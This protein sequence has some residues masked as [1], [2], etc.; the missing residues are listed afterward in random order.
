MDTLMADAAQSNPA[1]DLGALPEWNLADLYPGTDSK[2]LGDDLGG[3]PRD[4]KAFKEFYAGKVASQTGPGLS[5]AIAEYERLD[6]IIGRVISYAQLVYAGDMS[7]S[8]NGKFYQSMQERVTEIGSDL[9]FFSLEINRIKD[10]DLEAKLQAP[11]LARYQPWLR[12]VRVFRPHQLSDELEEMLHEK[13]VAG[14]GAWIRDGVQRPGRQ[15]TNVLNLRIVG[16]GKK[17]VD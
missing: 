6:E 15:G 13:S 9:L 14:R 8:E 3:P 11:E 12:D 2:A 16:P 7:S 1:A 4:A 17:R 5:S 10:A